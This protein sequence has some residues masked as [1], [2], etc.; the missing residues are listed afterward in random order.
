[1][2]ERMMRSIAPSNRACDKLALKFMGTPADTKYIRPKGHEQIMRIDTQSRQSAAVYA[3]EQIITAYARYLIE[4]RA[5][6]NPDFDPGGASLWDAIFALS[7]HED[8]RAAEAFNAARHLPHYAAYLS[9]ELNGTIFDTGF[10]DAAER[11][12]D[13]HMTS[14]FANFMC[15][16]VLQLIGEQACADIAD[17][18]Y[19]PSA[20][21]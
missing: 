18:R 8:E 10:G 16:R 13:S 4:Q 7:V 3:A 14:A 2:Y 19:I 6:L 5:H 20:D 21:A 12:G 17:G 11:T 9:D 15:D 1:M